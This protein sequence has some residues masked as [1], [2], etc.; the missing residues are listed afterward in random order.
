MRLHADGVH[1]PV[2][3]AAAGHLQD[4]GGDVVDRAFVEHRDAVPP[5][6]LQPL[7]DA[8]DRDHLLRA[9]V[10]GDPGAHLPDRPEADHCARAAGLDVGV[11][12]RLPGSGEHVGQEQEPLV[13][14]LVRHLDRPELGLR[15]PQQLRL[16]AGHRPVQGG[17]AEQPR[18]LALLGDLGGL[19][20][21]EETAGAHPAVPAG[22]VE[23]DDHPVAGLDVADLGSDLLHDAHRLVA[24]DVT[25]R[26]VHPEYV[27]QVQVRAADRRRGHPHDR[28]R[29]FLDLR[30]RDSLHRHL[31][32][33][34]PRQR[35]HAPSSIRTEVDAGASAA[36]QLPTVAA[37]LPRPQGLYPSVQ[38]S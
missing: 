26:E 31:L 28:V 27:V 19:A 24:E 17:V 10:L 25:G 6:Q 37:G 34:L 14:V 21:R 23:R 2:D 16:R 15:H 22:D 38:F 32:R 1:D 4:R 12:H 36:A 33:A 9:E 7:R 11:L 20:L 8:V 3:P 13:G 35:S 5:G 29:R 18:A 30:I